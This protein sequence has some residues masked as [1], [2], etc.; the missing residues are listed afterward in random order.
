M[1][2]IHKSEYGKIYENVIVRAHQWI[3]KNCAALAWAEEGLFDWAA[4]HRAEE[5]TAHVEL[6]A[7]IDRLIETRSPL[8][9][10]EATV[11]EWARLYCR[12]AR[13]CNFAMLVELNQELKKDKVMQRSKLV[14]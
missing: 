13:F 10:F 2:T 14:A 1:K 4:K 9:Q 12:I 7:E 11:R 5:F 8:P 6:E 3:T